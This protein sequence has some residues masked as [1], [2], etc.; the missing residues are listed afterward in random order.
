[1]R[2]LHG[3]ALALLA[4]L[5]LQGCKWAFGASETPALGTTKLLDDLPKVSNSPKSPCWQQRE[6]AAQRAYIDSVKGGKEIVYAAPCDVDKPKGAPA[7][8]ASANG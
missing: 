5:P 1:M 4:S 6:I 7:T 2:K 8:V 3:L